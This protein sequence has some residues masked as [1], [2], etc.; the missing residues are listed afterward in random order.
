MPQKENTKR[1]YVAY[2][3]PNAEKKALQS[4][5]RIG[6]TAYLPLQ[7]VTRKWSDR[8]KQLELPLFSNYIFIKT[9]PVELHYPL[10]VKQLISYVT[11]EGKAA[12]V[13]D[14]LVETLRRITELGL[15]VSDESIYTTGTLVRI[16]DGPFEGIEGVVLRQN[17]KTK[18]VVRIEAMRR[19][20]S[21]EI[22]VEKVNLIHTVQSF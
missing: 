18:L 8:M 10:Q 13:S 19:S 9:S 12:F 7:K 14:K 11:F 4:L 2:T 15:Q 3:Y 6:V 20:V 22:G 16:S 21:V 17:G 5:N 1:W